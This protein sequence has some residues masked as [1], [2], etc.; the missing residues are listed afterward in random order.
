[1]K[2][3]H[4]TNRNMAATPTVS[5]VKSSLGKSLAAPHSI[6]QL[7]EALAAAD[8][9]PG[10]F[11]NLKEEARVLLEK[12]EKARDHLSEMI[13]TEDVLSIKDALHRAGKVKFHDE[14]LFKAA[15]A[16][17]NKVRLERRRKM[18]AEAYEEMDNV[19]SIV[20]GP[21][22]RSLTVREVNMEEY[23]REHEMNKLLENNSTILIDGEWLIN[24][25]PTKMGPIPSRKHVPRAGWFKGP[26]LEPEDG[27]TAAER[28]SSAGVSP[29]SGR[30]RTTRTR[31][32]DDGP[33]G[34]SNVL[35][36]ALSYCWAS[37]AHPDPLGHQLRKV[38]SVLRFIRDKVPEVGNPQKKR[39]K[40]AVF[41]DWMSLYQKEGSEGRT[42]EEQELFEVGLSNVNLWYCHQWTYKL[43]L[44]E[45]P[46]GCEKRT[47]YFESGWPTFEAA[48]A[49]MISHPLN[50]W[51]SSI[52]T[53][54]FLKKCTSF[55]IMRDNAARKRTLPPDPVAM[56]DLL[57]RKTF[58]NK[59]DKGFVSRLYTKVFKEVVVCTNTLD[60]KAGRGG[61][62]LEVNAMDWQEW[63]HGVARFFL[64]RVGTIN[65]QRNQHLR[66]VTF[67]TEFLELISQKGRVSMI[68]CP[69]PFGIDDWEDE[70]DGRVNWEAVFKFIYNRLAP[71]PPEAVRLLSDDGAREHAV[72]LGLVN[73]SPGPHTLAAD[74]ANLDGI[75]KINLSAIGATLHGSIDAISTC[76]SKLVE[77]KL[78]GCN[79]L[80]GTL[81]GLGSARALARIE[82]QDCRNLSGDLRA[83]ENCV[84][85]Q[86]LNMN[87]C[88]RIKGDLSPLIKTKKIEEL[89][90]FECT[91]IFGGIQCL[92]FC[93]KLRV[94]VI[95]ECKLHGA[96][97]ETLEHLPALEELNARGCTLLKGSLAPLADS[98]KRLRKINVCKCAG[99]VGDHLFKEAVKQQVSEGSRTTECSI[100]RNSP[101]AF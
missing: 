67:P 84:S 15:Q 10:M 24:Y 76:C 95:C 53:E 90:L 8:H 63:L 77:L 1:M 62:G 58:T 17:M 14:K 56:E 86:C 45:L 35:I 49:G 80:T 42:D 28:R 83:L 22:R 9:A 85:L 40:L 99:I 11:L 69:G 52:L 65:L 37:P 16:V 44:S 30:T 48:V 88:K 73:F 34:F 72:R 3:R 66:G 33:M 75:Q 38:Q 20:N 39:K 32:R 101:Y 70:A 81:D 92:S 82:I 96:I 41:W 100:N 91:G 55:K 29:A 50:V 71:L 79:H 51:D 21:G 13:R 47:S 12:L 18:A 46:P 74:L 7:Q 2:E 93:S 98:C 94:L 6:T 23:T 5:M 78:F 97:D 27:A 60:Y 64:K 59:S 31:Q 61:H 57:Q 43:I 36:I 87:G 89:S 19:S 26:I 54:Q 25:N 4:S 68:E